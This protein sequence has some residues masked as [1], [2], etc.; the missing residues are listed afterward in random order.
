M[1]IRFERRR[2]P[3]ERTY[4]LVNVSRVDREGLPVELVPGRTL[5]LS[6]DGARLE[7]DQA[8]PEGARVRVDVALREE[9]VSAEAEVRHVEPAPAGG[10]HVGVHFVDLAGRALERV[11]AFLRARAYERSRR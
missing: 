4:Q 9:L 2:E 1:V 7:L 6:R 11:D 8:L 3:R 10:Y 5:D